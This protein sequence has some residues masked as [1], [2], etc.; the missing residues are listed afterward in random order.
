[1]RFLPTLVAAGSL[2]GALPAAAATLTVA[3]DN[4]G[5]FVSQDGIAAYNSSGATLAGATVTATFA[6]GT[7][8]SG[9]IAA[10]GRNTGA[11]YGSG[12][13]LVQ[14]GTTYS[15]AF[16]LFNDYTSALVTLSIDLVPASAVFDLDF[17]GATGTDGSNLGRTLIQ[18]DSSGSEDGSGLTGDVVATYAGRVSV[19]SAA[20][21]GDLYT[22]LVLDLSGTLDG[23]LASGGEWY[24]IA[25]TDTLKTAG[26]LAP[27]P[28]PAGVLTLG[29]ALAGLGLLR[30]RKG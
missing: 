24:F 10:F 5:G 19:G 20:A 11:L 12:F 26:D 27:V 6:D 1:M 9:T 21:V 7:S 8:E 16:A 14:T 25:D 22:S 13:E 17:G 28:L 30:R 4:S 29:A 2:M 18:S 15:N 23:G 3:T